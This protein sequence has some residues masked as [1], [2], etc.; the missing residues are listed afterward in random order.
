MLDPIIVTGLPRSRTS[1]TMQMMELSGLFLGDAIFATAANPQGQRENRYIIDQIQKPHFKKFKF[2][3][4]GQ[5]PLPPLGWYEKDPKRRE[6]VLEIMK[7]QGLK[8]G[9]IWGF[10]DSKASLDWRA[11]SVAF[12][13]AFWVVTERKDEYVITSCLRT[14]FMDKYKD[15]NGWQYWIDEHKLR[16]DDMFKHLKKIRKLNTDDVVAFDFNVLEE[17]VNAVGLKW[18]YDKIKNQVQPV[19]R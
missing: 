2:C 18:D 13:H 17:I 8:P 5:K 9:M 6:N 19:R 4:K 14:S 16:F 3:P 11:W 12:P 15:R 1:M 7:G 10:K